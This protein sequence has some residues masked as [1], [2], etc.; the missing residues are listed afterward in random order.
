MWLRSG[1]PYSTSIEDPPVI[2][3]ILNHLAGKDL[4]G[5]SACFGELRKSTSCRVPAGA[6]PSAARA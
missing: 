5:L 3:R 4:A 1:H 2:E 6:W